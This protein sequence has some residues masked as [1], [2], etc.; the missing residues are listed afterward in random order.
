VNGPDVV[1]SPN[2]WDAPDVY[3][4]ENRAFDPDRRVEAAM[5]SVQDWAGARLL[6]L[7]CG[8]GFHLARWAERADQVLGVEPHG[9][10][11]AAA[12][13]RVA[14]V[15]PELPQRVQVLAGTA[16]A[17]PLA[18]ASVDVVQARWA[19]FFGPGCEPGLAEV[20]RVVRPGGVAFVVDNDATTSTFGGW[21][22]RANPR[23]DPHALQRFWRRQGWSRI[24]VATRWSMTS[25]VDLEAV[26]RIELPPEV[27][28]VVLDGHRG[29]QV[30]YAVDVWWRRFP[31]PA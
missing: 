18:D 2:I 14:D 31:A 7:G 4:V 8:N 26:T 19:Y 3:E 13:R 12:R 16:Q 23:L 20:A 11:A 1:R 27:A 28:D 30:D 24:P 9:P 21:F 15:D 29:T 25:R 6:D 5:A 10:L 17:L 22:Q